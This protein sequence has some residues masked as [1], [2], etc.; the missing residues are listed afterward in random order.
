MNRFR[1]IQTASILAITGNLVLSVAKIITGIL[2][3]SLSVLGDGLDSLSDVFI[4]IITL[5]ISF[6]IVKPPDKNFPYGYYRSETIA[7][8]VLAFLMFFAGGQLVLST[9]DKLIFH[10][11]NQLP[12]ML[13]VYVTILSISGK[14]LLAISQYVLGRKSNS[15]MIIANGKNMVND[16]LTSSGVLLGLIFIYYLNLPVIDRIIAF[17]IGLWIMISA[18]RIFS[19]TIKEVMEGESDMELY[20]ILFSLIRKYECFYNPHRVRIRRLGAYH[21]IEFDIEAVENCTIKEAH[22]NVI[23]LESDIKK[24]MPSVYDIFIHIEPLGN[25]EQHERWGLNEGEL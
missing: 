3:N 10:D 23:E 19:G 25:Y 18:V 7:T 2:S 5:I 1:I 20:N 21:L 12:G 6:L 14:L 9:V 16:I 15:Q 24:K 22:D 13:A 8:S 17:I 4:S 11:Y